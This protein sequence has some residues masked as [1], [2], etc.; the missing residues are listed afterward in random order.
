MLEVDNAGKVLYHYLHA[1]HVK[2]SKTTVYRLLDTPLGNSMRGISDALDS[3][4]INNAAY[5]LP[6]EF[7]DEL[8]A[9]CIVIMNDNDSPFCL[10]EKNRRNAY[11]PIPQPTP[12]SKQT[13]VLTEMDRQCIS[14]RSNGKY[15]SG[16]EL[17]AEKYNNVDS[18]PP[19]I[20]SRYH[21]HSIDIIQHKA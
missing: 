1:L 7:L 16:E 21:C 12:E 6:K 14:G 19:T 13:A 10:I 17:Q 20:V 15:H 11:H 9:P 4:H 5:Q 18:T 3:L 2:V 8:E